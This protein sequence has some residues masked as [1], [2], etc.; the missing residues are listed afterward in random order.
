MFVECSLKGPK[1]HFMTKKDRDALTGPGLDFR[2]ASRSEGRQGARYQHLIG[3][4]SRLN[5][6]GRLCAY[7]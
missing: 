7:F 5:V 4:I 2:A 1:D 6:G 3:I